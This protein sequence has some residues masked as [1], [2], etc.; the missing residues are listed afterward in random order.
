MS[1]VDRKFVR[2]VSE[3]EETPENFRQS[4]WITA[5]DASKDDEMGNQE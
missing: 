1:G 4:R 5:R 2:R 3:E